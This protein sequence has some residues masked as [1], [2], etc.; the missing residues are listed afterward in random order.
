MKVMVI[1]FQALHALKAA[2]EQLRNPPAA[3]AEPPAPENNGGH[4]SRAKA[5]A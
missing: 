2:A 5:H 1:G 4:K 3:P